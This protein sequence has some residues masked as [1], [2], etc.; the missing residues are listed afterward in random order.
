MARER[1]QNLTEQGIEK[2]RQYHFVCTN[3]LYEVI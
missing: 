3:N 2:R 1:Y